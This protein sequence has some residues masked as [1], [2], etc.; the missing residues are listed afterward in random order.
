MLCFTSASVHLRFFSLTSYI[1][2]CDVC[3]ISG[4]VR[5]TWTNPSPNVFTGAIVMHSIW[6]KNHRWIA[7][8]TSIYMIKFSKVIFMTGTSTL[9]LSFFCKQTSGLVSPN[10]SLHSRSRLYKNLQEQIMT[11]YMSIRRERFC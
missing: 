8:Q 3:N 5:V 1:F 9:Q 2:I 4:S 6:Y 7:M 11:S 10:S